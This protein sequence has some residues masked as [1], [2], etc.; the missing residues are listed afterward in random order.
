MSWRCLMLVKL[1]WLGYR[2]V[3]N[4]WRYVKP[5][6]SDTGTSRTDGQTDRFAISISRVSMLTRDNNAVFWD[7]VYRVK[8]QRRAVLRT[9]EFSCLCMHWFNDEWI[10]RKVV[11]QSWRKGRFFS[12]RCKQIQ[13]CSVRH[14][15]QKD[16]TNQKA[17][18]VNAKKFLH[19]REK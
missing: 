14:F 7:M 1:E 15:V 16:E 11:I 18:C 12:P 5:F 10:V 6:S 8:F 19:P 13:S 3:N 4:L 9:T 17:L 2:M